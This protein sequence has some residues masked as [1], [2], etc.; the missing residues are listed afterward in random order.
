MRAGIGC[1]LKC[2]Q[3]INTNTPFDCIRPYSGNTIAILSKRHVPVATQSIQPPVLQK[4]RYRLRAAKFAVLIFITQLCAIHN[5]YT[6]R[7]GDTK[8]VLLFVDVLVYFGYL[9]VP[10]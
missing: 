6:T 2:T 8:Y 3:K 10:E 5:E 7:E 4:D 1:E 9:I